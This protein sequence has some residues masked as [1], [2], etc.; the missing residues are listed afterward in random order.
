MV[1]V[2]DLIALATMAGPGRIAQ[3]YQIVQVL[4]S[5]ECTEFAH[6]EGYVGVIFCGPV[7]I[8]R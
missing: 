3:F 4:E 5:V 2:P 8:A 7:R 1:Y 6:S